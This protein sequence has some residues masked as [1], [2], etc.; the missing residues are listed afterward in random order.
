MKQAGFCPDQSCV[1]ETLRVITG[2]SLD[3]Q[4][5]LYLLFLEYSRAFDSLQRMY[6][7]STRRKKQFIFCTQLCA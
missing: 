5:L 2:Q 3:F 6:L 1:D 7:E 4:F